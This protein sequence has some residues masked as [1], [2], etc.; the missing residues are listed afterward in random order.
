MLA[1][2][3]LLTAIALVLILEGIMPFANPRGLRRT[4]ETIGGLSDQQLR[5]VGVAC[6]VLGLVLLYIV[7]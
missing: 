5:G 1:W 4:L 3:D 6:M 7:H 2:H